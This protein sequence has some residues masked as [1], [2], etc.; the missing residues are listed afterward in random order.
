M[1]QDGLKIKQDRAKN[2]AKER[3]CMAWLEQVVKMGPRC[4]S[5]LFKKK[6]GRRVPEILKLLTGQ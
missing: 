6:S 4:G 3:T 5:E 2:T 1:C